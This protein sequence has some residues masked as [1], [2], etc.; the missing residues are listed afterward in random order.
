MQARAHALAL[1]RLF[2]GESLAQA[3]Q[4]GHLLVGPFDSLASGLGESEVMHV[5]VAAV[6][7]GCGI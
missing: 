6:A 5:E 3:A 2:F 1:E 7:V 4:H